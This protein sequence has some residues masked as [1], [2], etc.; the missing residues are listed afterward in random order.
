MDEYKVVSWA[1]VM[2]IPLFFIAWFFGYRGS[3]EF[4]IHPETP[5]QVQFSNNVTKN[6]KNSPCKM[7]LRA[8]KSFR[9]TIQA[10]GFLMN[11]FETDSIRVFHTQKI[12]QTLLPAAKVETLSIESREA[13]QKLLREKFVL[14]TAAIFGSPLWDREGEFVI[15]AQKQGSQLSINILDVQGSQK[16]LNTITGIFNLGYFRKN[17]A[18]QE[19][20]IVI[21]EQNNL[22]FYNFTTRRR[23]LIFQGLLQYFEDISIGN[24]EFVARMGTR[25]YRI[26]SKEKTVL[27]QDTIRASFHRGQL[28][29]LRNDDIFVEGKKIFTLDE[30]IKNFEKTWF[31]GGNLLLQGREGLYRITFPLSR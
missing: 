14:D 17:F 31:E 26:S 18:L 3:V 13:Q 8:G 6:C 5:F 4:G 21:P 30:N 2:V 20:G 15:F 22:Y 27:S 16:I 10:E 24:G 19:D 12:S 9:G 7:S 23:E 28:Y 29:E 25:W 11:P 1:V